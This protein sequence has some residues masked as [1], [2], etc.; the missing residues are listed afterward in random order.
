VLLRVSSRE[1][2]SLSLVP[3]DV[4]RSVVVL[5]SITPVEGLRAPAVGIALA[6]G[7]VVTVFCLDDEGLPA[8]CQNERTTALLCDVS[9]KLIAIASRTIEGSGLFEEVR[10]GHVRALETEAEVLD[11]AGVLRRAEEAIWA[12]REG[13]MQREETR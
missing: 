12:T 4:V 5:S 9:G 6:G 2:S 13:V 11:V 3:A 1:R 10:P 7:E 8:S